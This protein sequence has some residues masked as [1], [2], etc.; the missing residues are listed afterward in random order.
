MQECGFI[1][2]P[3]DTNSV[4]WED[5]INRSV[6]RLPPFDTGTKE[7]GF[8]DA[9][10]ANSFLQLHQSSP[11]TP[12]KC[13]IAFVTDDKRLIEYLAEK[14][15]DAKNVRLLSGSD[16]LEGLI[17]ALV[18]NVSEDIVKQLSKKAAKLFFEKQNNKSLYFKHEI[19]ETIRTKYSDE[20]DNNVIEGMIRDNDT[21]W[22]LPPVFIKKEKQR[23]YWSNNV[24][25]GFELYNFEYSS[26]ASTPTNLG[27]TSDSKP[28]ILGGFRSLLEQNSKSEK[29]VHHKG[30]VK[31]E[32]KWSTT[33]S[34]AQNLTTPQIDNISY[35]GNSLKDDV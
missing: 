33:L 34:T 14:T 24:E 32:V 3:C 6:N 21:W 20:L 9:I 10:I 17:N 13:M 18:S 29:K 31:F 28:N 19:G 30:R 1:T 22:I 7:K 8:R 5:I 4:D 15:K 26:I 2:L 35:I 23:I 16:E 25:V 27:I 11:V 12:S